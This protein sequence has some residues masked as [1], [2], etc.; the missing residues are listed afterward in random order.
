M[1]IIQR[2]F[3]FCVAQLESKVRRPEGTYVATWPFWWKQI[4]IPL[5]STWHPMEVSGTDMLCI[6][7]MY[8]KHVIQ[9]FR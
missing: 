6:R 7:Y 8:L 3:F 9:T 5:G 1:E 4:T 2:V